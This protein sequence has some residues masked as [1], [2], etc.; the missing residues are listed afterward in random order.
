[1]KSDER[2]LQIVADAPL[3]AIDLILQRA[4]GRVLLG[5]RANRPAQGFWFVPG[6][7]VLKGE[8]L[9]DALVRIA[10][11]ELGAAVPVESWQFVAPFE[12]FYDD[13]FLNAPGI[14]TQYV[15]LAHRLTL[16]DDAFV[17]Q[18]DDQHEELRWFTVAEAAGDAAVH[19]NAQAYFA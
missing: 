6:G 12:H 10:R 16:P 13:N 8:R 15:V 17:P 4:D 18:A 19:P 9:A 1:V 11:R 2:W 3:V 5:K 14:G 7:R